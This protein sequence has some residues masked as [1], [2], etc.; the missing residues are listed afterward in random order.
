MTN[1]ER[2]SPPDGMKIHDPCFREAA[3]EKYAGRL[4]D[5]DVDWDDYPVVSHS[6][7][8]AYVQAWLWVSNKDA[9]LNDEDSE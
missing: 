2:D 7:E 5:G 4:S 3:K 9:G 6:D 8:G 1:T